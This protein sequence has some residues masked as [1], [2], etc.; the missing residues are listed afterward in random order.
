MAKKQ[1]KPTMADKLDT[2]FGEYLDTLSA[3]QDA[4]KEKRKALLDDYLADDQ[5]IAELAT[6]DSGMD[7]ELK[8]ADQGMTAL[9]DNLKDD[10]EELENLDLDKVVGWLTDQD[11]KQ[12]QVNE[13]L[14]TLDDDHIRS[15]ANGDGDYIL[16]KVNG[17]NHRDMIEEFVKEKIYPSYNEQ[18]EYVIM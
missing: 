3:I 5:L 15:Y 4:Y 12:K 1:E 18:K 11:L 7:T 10:L 6:A 2:L 17:M 8:A 9:L 13:I 16:I 14:D